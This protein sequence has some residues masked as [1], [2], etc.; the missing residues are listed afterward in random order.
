MNTIAK[1]VLILS[2]LIE[3]IEPMNKNVIGMNIEQLIE[4][5][6]EIVK[7]YIGEFKKPYWYFDK[8]TDIDILIKSKQKP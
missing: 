6:E 1:N 8:L 7:K 5:R 4:Y 3:K 2:K